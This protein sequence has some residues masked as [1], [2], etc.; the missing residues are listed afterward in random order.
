MPLPH[1]QVY[2]VHKMCSLYVDDEHMFRNRSKKVVMN[3]QRLKLM[4]IENLSV[5]AVMIAAV[6]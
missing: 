4:R 6:V 3:Y 1:Y 5:H 2:V